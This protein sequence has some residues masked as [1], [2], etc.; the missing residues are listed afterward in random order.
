MRLKGI[1]TL[2]NFQ[3]KFVCGALI[4]LMAF[5]G[6]ANRPQS[7]RNPQ[8]EALLNAARAGHADTVKSLLAAKDVDVNATDEKGNTALIEAARYGHNDV[9]RALLI[10]RAD[11]NA[12]NL[13]GKTALMYA[14]QGG[15]DEVAQLLKQSG[16]KE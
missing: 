4:L 15:H 2:K 7:S 12:K 5:G 16:A 10:A 14:V 11:S 8:T 6:C 9:V 3:A 1:E 13:E